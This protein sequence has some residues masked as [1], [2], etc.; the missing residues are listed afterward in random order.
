MHVRINT[1][2]TK[3][4]TYR[5]V[6]IVQSY[7]RPSDGKP[8]HRVIASFGDLPELDTEN[9]KA[10]IK[11]SREGMALVPKKLTARM[12]AKIKENLHYGDVRVILELW[13]AWGLV[14]I[15]DE[16]AGSPET[17]VSV[18]EMVGA[19]VAQRC[20][21]P[22]SKLAACTWYPTTALPL[23][24]GIEPSQFNNTRIHR[25][26]DALDGIRDELQE[27]L[28]RRIRHRQGKAV[29]LFLDC[30]DTWFHGQGPEMAYRGPV[31]EGTWHRRIGIALL[32]DDKGL[33]MR[34]ATL[35]GNHDERRTMLDTIQHV[36]DLPWAQGVPL[37]VDR[38]LGSGTHIAEMLES[39]VHF[40]TAVPAP[41]L[42]GYLPE[43]FPG[44]FDDVELTGDDERDRASL[45]A[46]ALELGFEKAEGHRM[47]ADL[48]VVERTDG[49]G[50]MRLRPSRARASV[51]IARRIRKELEERGI[52]KHQ[53]AEEWGVPER[54]LQRL[55]YPIQLTE[56]VQARILA[57]E[58]DAATVKEIQDLGRLSPAIQEA[59]FE[60]LLGKLPRDKV[61]RPGTAMVRLLDDV[62]RF[63]VR[64]V[65]VFNPD[66]FL[67]HRRSALQAVEKLDHL[68]AETNAN[69]RSGRNQNPEAKVAASIEEEIRKRGLTSVFAV[70]ITHATTH[71]RRHPV[72]HLKRDDA[73]WHRRRRTD[74]FLLIVASP[75]IDMAADEL[76]DTYYG[77]DRVEKDFRDI[78]SVLELRP[79]HHSTDRKVR[80]HVDLCM[81]A[82]LI[83]RDLE[84]R[85][86]AK[87]IHTSAPAALET[88]STLMLNRIDAGTPTYIPTI[89][90]TEQR[91]ILSALGM[92][93]IAKEDAIDGQINANSR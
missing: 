44:A 18:G 51:M 20:T 38:A 29:H 49:T 47:I 43:N 14:E 42:P 46:R 61:L 71:G 9:L 90:N 2:R 80:A 19:L 78:K 67:Q 39:G 88:L 77:K 10:A 52:S 4:K 69:L 48:G 11:A 85:L 23:L 16:L 62:P 68:V 63:R 92:L 75:H 93:N 24:Q 33:P 17:A 26:L 45:E 73:A 5:S 34:W 60:E 12:I 89:P 54:Q 53:L 8:V 22:A 37:V 64:A 55:C 56:K 36:A 65:S 57:G 82:L 87:G 32:C 81:L 40:V 83:E 74:G 35:P 59:A 27:R 1:K 13:R 76:I 66:L 30:T 15:I 91:R 41:E 79:I 86:R 72:V 7:R 50:A 28:A 31:K 58:A 6:Q 25:T 3:T 21:A 84:L 70:R